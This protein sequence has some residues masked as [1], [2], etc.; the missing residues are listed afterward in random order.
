VRDLQEPDKKMSTTG[1]TARGTVYVDEERDSIIKKFKSA[2]TDSGREI[3]RADDKPGIT[4]LIE[5][6]ARVRGTTPE[7]I[8]AEYPG[9]QRYGDFK[10]TVGEEV[11]DW[12][13]PVRERYADLRE[14]TEAIEEILATGAEKAHALAA[15]V[16]DD[17]REVMG[18][19]PPA[20]RMG[21]V[22]ADLRAGARHRLPLGRSVGGAA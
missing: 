19:G 9:E 21:G 22:P 20:S 18:V 2:Q 10:L 11:A 7:A 5:I 15:P 3:V 8:E 1:G 12:L 4:N 13:A 17:V 6:L 16:L 14:D